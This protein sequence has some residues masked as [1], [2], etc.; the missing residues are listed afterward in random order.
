MKLET[1]DPDI[2]LRPLD[3][4]DSKDLSRIANNKNIW[5]N[6]R[7]RFPHP[8]EEK[9]AIEFISMISESENDYVF[10]IEYKSQLVGVLGL[11]GQ[12]DVYKHSAELGYFIGEDF[13]N[14]GIVGKAV[15]AA[16]KY[17]F[18]TLNIHRIFASV[19]GNNP[20]SMRVL[21][22]NGFEREG[23]KKE[24]IFKNGNILDE[25]SYGLIN[26]SNYI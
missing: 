7:D 8:Y 12:G 13:W 14:K 17:A 16:V 26:K 20:A 10:A 4:N 2:I 18:E 23:I 1:T 3:I 19:F 11:H 5:L 22:K 21:E 24:A 9:D 15:K 25:H 6:V